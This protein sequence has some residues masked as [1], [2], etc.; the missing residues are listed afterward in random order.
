MFDAMR[1]SRSNLP[2]NVTSNTDGLLEGISDGEQGIDTLYCRNEG[3]DEGVPSHR[4]IASRRSKNRW[5]CTHSA[6]DDRAFA[7]R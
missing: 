5:Q 7:E 2:G 4:C 6:F 1:K 3:S